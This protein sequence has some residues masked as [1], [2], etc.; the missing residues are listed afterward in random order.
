[1]C[2]KYRAAVLSPRQGALRLRQA[3]LKPLP[4]MQSVKD[5]LSK[6]EA[7]PPGGFPAIRYARRLPSNG[8]TGATLFAVGAVISLYGFYKIG[9][10]NQKRRCGSWELWLTYQVLDG[11]PGEQW[12][13]AGNDERRCSK[14]A[15]IRFHTFKLSMMCAT[16]TSED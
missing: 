4:C 2:F 8:P 13:V 15:E 7:A 5:L 16:S 1:M 3:D 10:M 11:L 6:E 14:L 12:L 9:V